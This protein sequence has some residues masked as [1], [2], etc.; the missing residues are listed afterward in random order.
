M[1]SDN[2]CLTQPVR[3]LIG[4][5]GAYTFVVQNPVLSLRLL[6]SLIIRDLFPA[7]RN[8]SG[9]LT[10]T[11]FKKHTENFK[12]PITKKFKKEI[13]DLI[14]NISSL[15]SFASK[16]EKDN[17]LLRKTCDV[18]E[19]EVKELKLVAH[20]FHQSK[21]IARDVITKVLREVE[22]R[23]KKQRNLV[24][25][26]VPEPFEEGAPEQRREGDLQQCVEILR[27]LDVNTVFVEYIVCVS[28]EVVEH[29]CFAWS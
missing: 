16:V 23:M 5:S 28:A 15:Q 7:G 6:F 4:A 11:D 1:S 2:Y 22:E 26:G 25:S 14:C 10:L 17:A 9:S 20:N 29:V 19:D 3:N 13:E 12:T 18:L 21:E 27:Y 8:R 24:F